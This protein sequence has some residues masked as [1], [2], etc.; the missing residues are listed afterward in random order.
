M[1]CSLFIFL[2]LFNC[3]NALLTTFD[4]LAAMT[5]PLST[6]WAK[7]GESCVHD[8]SCRLQLIDRA[9]CTILPI[10]VSS[11]PYPINI[12]ESF[13]LRR[14]NNFKMEY[15][16]RIHSLPRFHNIVKIKSLI[17]TIRAYCTLLR[18]LTW[19][20]SCLNWITQEKSMNIFKLL[21]MFFDKIVTGLALD[22][23]T[24][25]HAGLFPSLTLN[26]TQYIAT[27]DSP[28]KL[29]AW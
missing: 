18:I 21:K 1:L 19:M 25:Y 17:R 5:K 4:T 26:K 6:A 2:S 10:R 27:S 13:S 8:Q 29:P 23:R 28:K 11:R 12:S 14:N 22:G 20:L 24:Y 9:M 7:Y 15:I 3:Q 16:Q